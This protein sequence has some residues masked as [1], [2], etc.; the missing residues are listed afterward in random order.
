MGFR[1]LEDPQRI[2][3]KVMLPSRVVHR[4]VQAFLGTGWG[5]GLTAPEQ[6]QRAK[7]FFLV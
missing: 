4:A 1:T 2:K 5:G 6:N 7:E 3:K